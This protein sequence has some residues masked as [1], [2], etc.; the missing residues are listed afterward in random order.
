MG[1]SSLDKLWFTHHVYD[2]VLENND[3][4]V[5]LSEDINR[6]F[7]IASTTLIHFRHLVLFRLFLMIRGNR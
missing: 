2:L 1:L 7:N 5:V 3:P 6:N 4:F